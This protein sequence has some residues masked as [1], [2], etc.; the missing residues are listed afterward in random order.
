ML[1]KFLAN[2]WIS[3]LAMLAALG[4]FFVSLQVK[5]QSQAPL[6]VRSD[7]KL[8]WLIMMLSEDGRS[9]INK[10]GLAMFNITV[11]NPSS[12]D[13]SYFD[14][15]VTDTEHNQELNFYKQEHLSRINDAANME[16]HT[17]ISQDTRTYIHL[18]S[19][20]AGILKAHSVT[21]LSIVVTPEDN[22]QKVGV[23]FKIA[24]RHPLLSSNRYGFV[25]SKYESLFA[26]AVL[27]KSSKPDY[28]KLL[29]QSSSD[30]PLGEN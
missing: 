6:E 9:I 28:E 21:V 14:M 23:V 10:N 4:S 1:F 2:N 5:R 20:V 30:K 13:V 16:I 3:M 29:A 27:D 8:E 7:E 24:R 19:G 15:R 18:P 22:T 11:I 25:F 17:G 26:S 12:I